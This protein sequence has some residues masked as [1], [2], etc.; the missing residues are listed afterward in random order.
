M[1]KQIFTIGAFILSGVMMAQTEEQNVIT[2]TTTTTTTVTE[3]PISSVRK[4]DVIINPIA[5]LLGVGNISYERH[6]NKDMG[7]GITTF[8]VA[9]NYVVGEDASF[10]YVFPHYRYYM[11]KRWVRGF[12]VE[13]FTG[14]LSRTYGL[15]HPY[16]SYSEV[17]RETNFSLGFGFGGKWE[18]K[19]NIVFETSLGIGRAFGSEYTDTFFLKGMLGIGYRF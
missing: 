5:V 14:V 10:W 15:Y 17:K 18:T 6:L 3:Q 12:F 7:L 9:D 4:N 1:I 2:T 13:A 19:R 8:F 11:G 16:I